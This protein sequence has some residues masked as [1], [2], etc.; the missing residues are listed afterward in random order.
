MEV[1]INIMNVLIAENNSFLAYGLQKIVQSCGCVICDIVKEGNDAVRKSKIH[2]PELLL[3]DIEL[4]DEINGVEAA[5][6]I[7][8]EREVRVVF[9][10]GKDKMEVIKIAKDIKNYK[11]ISKPYNEYDI[12]NALS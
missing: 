11:I 12:K 8:K 4:D 2:K 7:Q 10:T 6:L 9:T 3:F 1:C 5:A